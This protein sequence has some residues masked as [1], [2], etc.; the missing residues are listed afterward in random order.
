MRKTLLTRARSRGALPGRRL[1]AASTPL[2]IRRRRRDQLPARA[3]DGG[4]A[5]R[6]SPAGAVPKRTAPAEFAQAHQ[7]GAEEA[8]VLAVDN[9]YS[10]RGE[11]LHQASAGGRGVPASQQRAARPGWSPSAHEALRAHASQRTA[12]GSRPHSDGA[13]AGPAVGHVALRR[14]R[15]VVGAPRPHV[16]RHA[17]PGSADRRPRPRLEELALRCDR[18][19]AA[20]ERRRLR[21]R[22]GLE[23]REGAAHALA[24]ATGGKVF[25]A[26]DTGSLGSTYQAPQ[27]GARPDVADL[28]T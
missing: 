24:S 15:P 18:G 5:C 1:P 13:R 4:R 14:G 8:I 23:G 21:D 17:D 26:A 6:G 16:E 25:D 10:M 7:L 9:S 19:R 27:P 20:G 12:R 28:I 3:R 11:P 2:Q 22:R